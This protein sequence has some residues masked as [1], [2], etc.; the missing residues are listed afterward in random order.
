MPSPL[1]SPAGAAG[2]GTRRDSRRARNLRTVGHQSHTIGPVA[3]YFIYADHLGSTVLLTCYLQGSACPDGTAAQYI[4]YDAYGTMKA[5]DATGAASAVSYTDRLYTGQRWDAVALAYDYGA[6]FYD[7]RLARFLT[8]DPVREYMNPYAYVQWNPVKFVDPTG[9]EG[10]L[11]GGPLGFS[12]LGYNGDDA[13]KL[14]GPAAT[15]ITGSASVGAN[16][17]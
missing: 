2:E 9:M 6:R 12:S 4:R 15:A 13:G 1:P 8:H 11:W 14:A 17:A 3:T 10:V 7:P 16:F 5:F